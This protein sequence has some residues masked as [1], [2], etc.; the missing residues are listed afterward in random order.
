[1]YFAFNTQSCSPRGIIASERRM[2]A[3]EMLSERGCEDIEQ[4][5]RF[6]GV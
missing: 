4:L 6:A 1:M 2:F 5:L 3:V